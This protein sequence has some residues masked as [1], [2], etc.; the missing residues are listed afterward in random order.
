M[1]TILA[2]IVQTLEKHREKNVGKGEFAVFMTGDHGMTEEGSHGGS[3][4][5]ETEVALVGFQ[6]NHHLEH[7]KTPITNIEQV[8]LVSRWVINETNFHDNDV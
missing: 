5:L 7:S 3:S 4:S 6:S 2:G 8:D 1:D